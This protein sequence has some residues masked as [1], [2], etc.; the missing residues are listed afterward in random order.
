M[1][2][3]PYLR[4][5]LR[6]LGAFLLVVWVV[7][8][9]TFLIVRLIPGDPARLVLGAKASDASVEALRTELGL[10]ESILSQYWH[11]TLG[12]VHLDFGESFTS[13][14]PV[15]TELS[16]RIVNELELIGVAVAIVLVAGVSLG[17]LFGA[18]TADGR[19]PWAEHGFVFV[20]GFAG[21]VPGYVA[22]TVL[23]LLFAVTWQ[24]FPVGGNEGP[25][26]VVLPALSIAIPQAALLA[27]IVRVETLGVLRQNYVRAARSKRLPARSIYGRY[28]LPNVLTAALT[29]GGTIFAQSIGSAIIVETVF[30]WNGLGLL[31]TQ[32]VLRLNFPVV[33]GAALLLALIVV[34]VNALVDIAVSLIDPR[35]AAQ[36]G[37]ELA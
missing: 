21:S 1:S 4:F 36:R 28:V 30:S 15:S 3:H 35:S 11:Y 19:R 18:L 14:V 5:L 9:A 32:S 10:N 20:T 33:Q 27:R 12:A 34:L 29:L 25:Q 31:L 13:H 24:L 37:L 8:I 26:S 2:G 22:A 23:S 7:E 16:T 17:I 6:R